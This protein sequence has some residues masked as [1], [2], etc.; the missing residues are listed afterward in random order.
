MMNSMNKKLVAELHDSQRWDSYCEKRMDYAIRF[1]SVCEAR[2]EP[3]LSYYLD[4]DG[5]P[6]NVRKAQRHYVLDPDKLE[7]VEVDEEL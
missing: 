3:Y 6:V 5:N 2:E 4:D 7:Y 1:P